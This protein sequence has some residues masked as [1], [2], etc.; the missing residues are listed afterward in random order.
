MNRHLYWTS[1]LLQVLTVF[2]LYTSFFADAGCAL[3]GLLVSCGTKWFSHRS[4]LQLLT[5]AAY[6]RGE[7]L[8]WIWFWHAA[9]HCHHLTRFATTEAGHVD[10]MAWQASLLHECHACHSWHILSF[11]IVAVLVLPSFTFLLFHHLPMVDMHEQLP[12]GCRSCIG[13]FTNKEIH[14]CNLT[15]WKWGCLLD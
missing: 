5:S 8:K 15:V 12:C 7:L 4:P 9:P 6:C 1:K 11:L 2:M 14:C 3:D 10:V 13:I